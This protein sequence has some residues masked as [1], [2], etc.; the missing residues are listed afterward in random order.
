MQS[1]AHRRRAALLRRLPLSRY[2]SAASGAAALD[3]LSGCQDAALTHSFLKLRPWERKAPQRS[4]YG[5]GG[6]HGSS[7]Y[8]GGGG[9]GSGGYGGSFGGATRADA[10][11]SW[12]RS[13]SGGYGGIRDDSFGSG[14]YGAGDGYSG[15]KSYGGGGGYG[16]SGGGASDNGGG[17][18]SSSYGATGAWAD[19]E[20]EL[21]AAAEEWEEGEEDG[22]EEEDAWDPVVEL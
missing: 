14:G 11:D 9:Y 7:S 12:R 4:S 10:A 6:G 15:S 18:G 17:G 5:G 3:G 21:P 13:S 16:S 1:S 19:A 2:D 22:E 8:A 20:D